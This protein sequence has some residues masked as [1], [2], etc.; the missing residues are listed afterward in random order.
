MY[1][2]YVKKKENTIIY[3]IYFIIFIYNSIYLFFILFKCTIKSVLNVFLLS[4]NLN[5]KIVSAMF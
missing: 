1:K 4:N 3:I 2:K 5:I